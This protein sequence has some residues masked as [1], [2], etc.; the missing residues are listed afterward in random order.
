MVGKI[1]HTLELFFTF[2]F[3]PICPRG[4]KTSF[5]KEQIS[6]V[7]IRPFAPLW[8]HDSGL[9]YLI[10]ILFPLSSKESS[11]NLFRAIANAEKNPG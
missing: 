1:A 2:Y 9:A 10:N 5:T 3:V 11:A 6:K 7:E 8:R 4:I